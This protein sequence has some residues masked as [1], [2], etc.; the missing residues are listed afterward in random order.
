MNR[1]GAGATRELSALV[2]AGLQPTVVVES[3][4]VA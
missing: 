2:A 1:P 3:G 4:N